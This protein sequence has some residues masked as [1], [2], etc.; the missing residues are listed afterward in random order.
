MGAAVV[1]P[2]GWLSAQSPGVLAP[3][4]TPDLRRAEELRASTLDLIAL[5]DTSPAAG[6]GGRALLAAHADA[7]TLALGESSTPDPVSDP[8]RT[9]T[10]RSR[11]ASLQDSA[12]RSALLADSGQFAALFASITSS[13]AQVEARAE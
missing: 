5:I 2:L 7:L 8:R 1:A 9:G 13:L 3:T 6:G 11:R 12:R 10:L 4:L